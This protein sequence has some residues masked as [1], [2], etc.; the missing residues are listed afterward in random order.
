MCVT[1]VQCNPDDAVYYLPAAFSAYRHG[2]FL[3]NFFCFFE[4]EEPAV[5]AVLQD[6]RRI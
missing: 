1:A 2:F 6:Y 3:L 5:S 4:T